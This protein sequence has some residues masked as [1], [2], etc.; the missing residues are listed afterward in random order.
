MFLRKTVLG[1]FDKRE[2]RL[3]DDHILGSV[4]LRFDR[5]RKIPQDK[6]RR[7]KVG[8]DLSYGVLEA[9]KLNEATGEPESTYQFH[10]GPQTLEI[11]VEWPLPGAADWTGVPCDESVAG[12]S[13][14]AVRDGRRP[15]FELRRCRRG[16]DR[17]SESVAERERRPEERRQ[18]D[19]GFRGNKDLLSEEP[20]DTQAGEIRQVI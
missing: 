13:R 7:I 8:F 18:A 12:E 19:P 2:S 3:L 10:A 15:R 16:R 6:R 14:T 4:E 11:S 1:D 17:D 20:P 9:T 5:L